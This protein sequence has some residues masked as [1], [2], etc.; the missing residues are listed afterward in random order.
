M[1]LAKYT[2]TASSV[3]SCDTAVNDAPASSAKNTRDVIA[4]WP[5]D[6]TGR[7]SVRPWTTDRTTTCS[8][9]IGATTALSTREER[10]EDRL[11]TRCGVVGTARTERAELILA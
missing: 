4:R 7:N 9:D 3:P 10:T 5:D 1:S 6:D 11:S 2:R 8:H